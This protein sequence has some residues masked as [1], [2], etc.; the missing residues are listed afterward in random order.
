MKLEFEQI[1]ILGSGA[2][3]L[4]AVPSFFLLISSHSHAFVERTSPMRAAPMVEFNLPLSTSFDALVL[5]EGASQIAF[6]VDPPRPDGTSS[7]LRILVHLLQAKQ[8]RRVDLPA[9]IG[10]Q[11]SDA[12]AFSDRTDLF[13]LE[14]NASDGGVVAALFYQAP[15]GQVICKNQWKA[16]PQETPLDVFTPGSPFQEWADAKWWGRDLVAEK[17]AEGSSFHRFEINSNEID[18]AET[19]WFVYK[20]G[21]WQKGTIEPNVPIA[22]IKEASSGFVEIEGWDEKSCHVR[23]RLPLMQGN[24]SRLR[25]DELFSQLRVRSEKQISCILEKQCLILRIGDWVVKSKDRW[26][27]LRKKEEKE[28][29]LSGKTSGELFVLER[30]DSKTKQ[31]AGSLYSP[32]RTSFS[33]IEYTQISKKPTP[34]AVRNK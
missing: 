13:W 26:K 34:P 32:K 22:H 8:S 17:F 28:A 30:I 23:L 10:L 19:D 15:D 18:C 29:L 3:I 16:T 6:S 11:F 4:S 24:A 20:E 33:P 25:G 7:D 31:I 21:R 14:C 1:P 27:V 5:G 12:L 9:K 2:L